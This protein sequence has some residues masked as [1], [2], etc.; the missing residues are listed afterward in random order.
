MRKF[1]KA[2]FIIYADF[3]NIS[4]PSPDNNGDGPNTEKYQD[5]IIY[6]YSC[7][8]ISVDEHYSKP[9]ENYRVK[10]FIE[11]LQDFINPNL[12]GLSRGSFSNVGGRGKITSC[13]KLIRIML[14]T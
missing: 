7:K 1:L 3:E 5:H 11:R 2:P 13:L 6:S 4:K 10:D 14:E 8:F 9:Y 12:G